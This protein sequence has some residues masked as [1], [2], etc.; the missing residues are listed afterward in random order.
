MLPRYVPK[1]FRIRELAETC[2]RLLRRPGSDR[3]RESRRSLSLDLLALSWERI[4][5]GLAHLMDLSAGGAQLG[6]AAPLALGERIR[7]AFPV[8]EGELSVAGRV[9]WRDAGTRGFAHGLAF[10]ALAP[11]EQQHIARLLASRE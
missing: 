4:P 1:P 8:A 9:C 11:D 6:F 5:L 10:E 2:E 3:R 7:M